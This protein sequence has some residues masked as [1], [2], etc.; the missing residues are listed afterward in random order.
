MRIRY[1]FNRQL[2]A[3]CQ[4][5]CY[6]AF[7]VNLPTNQHTTNTNT[8]N[9]KEVHVGYESEIAAQLYEHYREDGFKYAEPGITPKGIA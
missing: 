9:N 6:L 8:L 1:G 4:S 2:S 7:G 3:L 5:L